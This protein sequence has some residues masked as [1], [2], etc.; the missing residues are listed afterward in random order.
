MSSKRSAVKSSE[1]E[2]FLKSKTKK[3]N[4]RSSSRDFVREVQSLHYTRVKRSMRGPYIGADI[5]FSSGLRIYQSNCKK[6]NF[7]FIKCTL[8]ILHSI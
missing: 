8:V 2:K 5:N 7:Y 1:C 6:F 4:A 3:K